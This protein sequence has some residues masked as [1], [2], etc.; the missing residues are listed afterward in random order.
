MEKCIHDFGASRTTLCFQRL[1]H[2]MCKRL[3]VFGGSIY[4]YIE[5]NGGNRMPNV[6]TVHCICCAHIESHRPTATLCIASNAWMRWIIKCQNVLY[7]SLDTDL[8]SNA[9]IKKSGEGTEI[10][11]HAVSNVL[12]SFFAQLFRASY[13]SCGKKSF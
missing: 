2:L 8:I 12:D 6:M 3:Y 10:E 11:S 13:F 7:F 1:I 9:K 5:K 4:T